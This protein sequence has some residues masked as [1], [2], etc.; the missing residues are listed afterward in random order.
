M[1]RLC[2]NS[3]KQKVDS[4]CHA[5][6]HQDILTNNKHAYKKAG[7]KRTHL[8]MSTHMRFSY[9]QNVAIAV[10]M[11]GSEHR[12]PALLQHE[13]PKFPWLPDM[14]S[15]DLQPPTNVLFDFKF[16]MGSA[17]MM[18]KQIRIRF[19]DVLCLLD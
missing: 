7:K 8:R 9:G 6:V 16:S 11:Q 19:F 17:S 15:C 2:F 14:L 4:G 18:V 5:H 12:V 13:A 1:S 10:T 3:V